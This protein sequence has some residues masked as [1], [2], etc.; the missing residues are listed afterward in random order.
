VSERDASKRRVLDRC[1]GPDHDLSISRLERH[2]VDF[3]GD[4]AAAHEQIARCYSWLLPR[5]GALERALAHYRRAH[6]LAPDDDEIL[7]AWAEV[8][9]DIDT[10]TALRDRARAVDGGKRPP[11]DPRDGAGWDRYWRY[12]LANPPD[13]HEDLELT[14]LVPALIEA[15]RRRVLDVGAGIS[16]E[17]GAFAWAGF[18]VTALDLSAT[19]CAH[20]RGQSFTAEHARLFFGDDAEVVR[21]DGGT[22]EH[23]VGDMFDRSRCPGPFDVVISRRTL[24]YYPGKM[25]LAALAALLGRLADPGVLVIHTHNAYPVAHELE[26]WLRGLG[27]VVEY[28]DQ[29]SDL[30]AVDLGRRYAGLVASSG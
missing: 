26:P 8:V 15:G 7:W 14:D 13:A 18:E 28:L 20:R 11:G 25:L 29:G 6:E 3:P 2:I 30:R 21:R 23:V 10:A 12:R 4:A 17:P 16:R 24:Q 5:P 1:V 22:L 19:A 9:A 27:F